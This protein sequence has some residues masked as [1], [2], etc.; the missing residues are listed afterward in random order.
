MLKVKQNISEKM[1]YTFFLFLLLVS[2]VDTSENNKDIDDDEE[3][4]K[5][6][7]DQQNIGKYRWK[8]Q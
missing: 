7:D 4:K 3:N 1:T 6:G 8:W 2:Q 5:A